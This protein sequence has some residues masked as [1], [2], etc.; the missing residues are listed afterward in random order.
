MNTAVD[1]S[2]V[3]SGEAWM[4]MTAPAKGPAAY[5]PGP[6]STDL[7]L[8]LDLRL[9]KVPAGTGARVDQSVILRRNANGDYRAMVRVQAN[10]SVRAGF[11]RTSATGVQTVLG[12]DVTISGLT[13]A[14]GD[15]LKVR[16][17]ATGT[18]PTTV[19]VKVWK[20]TATEPAA[21][22]ATATDSTAGLQALGSIGLHVYLGSS[23]T[24]APIK[25]RYDNLRAVVASTLP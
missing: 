13:Y 19:R 2:G 1:V 22:T 14:V 16:A 23:A 24:N 15:I 20:S 17:Q 5:L 8:Q 10:G 12:T 4:S 11:A 6:T 9:D 18:S 25:A 7:D 21:W 3:D